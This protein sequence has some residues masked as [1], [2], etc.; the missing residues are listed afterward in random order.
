LRAP[1]TRPAIYPTQGGITPQ[2]AGQVFNV[3]RALTISVRILIPFSLTGNG[4]FI[5]NHFRGCAALGL[6]G[7]F[8]CGGAGI[9]RF[10]YHP[11]SK[12]GSIID[13]GHSVNSPQLIHQ[14][15]VYSAPA[16]LKT[17]IP[18]IPDQGRGDSSQCLIRACVQSN[19][20][21]FRPKLRRP[22]SVIQIPYFCSPPLL[23]RPSYRQILDYPI[24]C[25]CQLIAKRAEGP[26]S[27]FLYIFQIMNPNDIFLWVRI[28]STIIA[29]EG[30]VPGCGVQSTL[31]EGVNF[32]YNCALLF[33]NNRFPV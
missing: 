13:C 19:F 11:V 15:R 26:K 5:A 27:S 8:H 28:Y 12:H 33:N 23:K 3:K 7:H 14:A 32:C 31:Q 22:P 2:E 18:L 16:F 20:Y 24:G 9:S 1:R 30:K 25:C 17:A 4:S 10:H 6:T 29:Q 21:L